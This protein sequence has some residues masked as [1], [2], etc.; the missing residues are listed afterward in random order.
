M[1][2]TD[3]AFCLQNVQ[4]PRRQ[5]MR[6]DGMHGVATAA[7]DAIRQ[8]FQKGWRAQTPDARAATAHKRA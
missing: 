8:L 2:Q 6:G 3:P 5:I 1:S 7:T 4:P